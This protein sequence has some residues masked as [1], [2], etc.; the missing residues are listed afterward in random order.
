M[1]LI[2]DKVG[3][4][5]VWVNQN[6]FSK[7]HCTFAVHINLRNGY[8]KYRKEIVFYGLYKNYPD[9]LGMSPLRGIDLYSEILY[10]II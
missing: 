9:L 2:I 4:I 7:Y 3:Y 8:T 1:K 5:Y 10:F 6:L